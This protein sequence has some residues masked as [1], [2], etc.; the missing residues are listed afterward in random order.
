MSTAPTLAEVLRS[1]QG[2]L[3]H[4][5]HADPEAD[6][7]VTEVTI[8]DAADPRSLQPGA[9]VLAVGVGEREGEAIDLLDR[10]GRTDGAAVVFR[11]ANELPA[12]VLDI[13]RAQGLTV[14]TVGTEVGWGHLYSLLRSALASAGATS[15]ADALGVRV[16]D[17]FALADAIAAAVGGPVTIEDPQM[18]VL[19]YSNLDQPIDEARRRTILGRAPPLDW[20][21]RLDEAGIA[22]HLRSG[23]G[24]VRYEAEGIAARLAVPVRAG[25]ESLGA[26]W[27]AEG[28]ESLGARAEAE[29]ERLA[30]LATVHLLA[31]RS[32]EDIRRRTLG[33]FI[34]EVLDGRVPMVAGGTDG[35]PRLTGPFTALAFEPANGAEAPTSPERLLSIVSLYAEA[36]HRDAICAYIDGRFWALVP[37]AADRPRERTAD[38]ARAIVE[39]VARSLHVDLSAGIGMSVPHLADVPRARRSAER[40]LTIAASRPGRCRVVRIEDVQAHAVL[41]ELLELTDGRPGLLQGRLQNLLDHDRRHGTDFVATLRAHLDS[42]CDIRR[43]GEQLGLHPNSVRYRVRRLLEISGLDLSDPEER[44]VTELQLR[45]LDS[46]GTSAPA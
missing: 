3:L 1:L 5:A 37:S 9:V 44:L 6:T 22:R 45:M 17:L 43:A 38:A 23:D 27:V 40:A 24:V 7:A 2:E 13:A 16:G 11:T 32:V 34:R 28:A 33:A 36:L 30:S 4:A 21:Q 20:Q 26:V 12:R 35:L 39:R 8:Y 19:A 25:G 31:H 15:Q 42:G 10:A 14:L 46:R 29:L 18:R 41:M